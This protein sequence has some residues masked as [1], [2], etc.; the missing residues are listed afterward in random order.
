[1]K[2]PIACLLFA[3]LTLAASGCG[4]NDPLNVFKNPSDVP[5]LQLPIAAGTVSAV[6]PFQPTG[7]SP[8]FQFTPTVV[9]I[10]A[11]APLEGLVTAIELSSAG[12]ALTIVYSTQ[13]S[14][15]VSQLL[16]TNRRVGDYVQSGNDIGVA[17]NNVHKVLIQ[18]LQNG[19]NVCPY[20]FFDSASRVTINGVLANP[21][22]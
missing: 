22:S 7:A 6:T 13:F 8:G 17:D 11:I 5:S 14:V 16:S 15:K 12:Y 3:A 19:T 4:G 20:S 21:C 9:S 10:T 1:M 18:L 2:K